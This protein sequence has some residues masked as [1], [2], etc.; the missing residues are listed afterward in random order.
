MEKIEKFI[1]QH[2]EKL[3]V[4]SP[5]KEC[6]QRFKLILKDSLEKEIV[7]HRSELNNYYSPSKNSWEAIENELRGNN[8]SKIDSKDKLKSTTLDKFEAPSGLWGKI[9]AE[10]DKEESNSVKKITTTKEVKFNISKQWL[11]IAAILI[12]GVGIGWFGNNSLKDTPIE[13]NTFQSEWNQAE[14]YYMTMISNKKFQ[15]SQLDFNDVQLLD[16]FNSQLKDLQ[17]SY[18]KLKKEEKSSAEPKIIRKQM[19]INLELQ[20]E[21][22]NKQMEIIIN[23]S[24]PKMNY[25]ENKQYNI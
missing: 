16:D 2:R 20:I 10:L 14:D 12:I 18:S 11:S 8:I 23:A 3:D 6:D 17:K 22:L 9:E 21:L 25:E 19:V 4:L 1:L 7:R 5:S 13:A 24:K 15:I